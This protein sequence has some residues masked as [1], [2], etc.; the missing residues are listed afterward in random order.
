M[1]TYTGTTPLDNIHYTEFIEYVVD[2]NVRPERPED[3]E[4]PQL[5]NDMWALAEQCWAGDRTRRPDGNSLCRAIDTMIVNT[6][7]N[8][9]LTPGINSNSLPLSGTSSGCSL[10]N[11]P[12]RPYTLREIRRLLAGWNKAHIGI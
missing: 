8:A 7:D 10:H 2:R 12:Q 11:I 3:D 6:K 1:Q 4:V 9:S 5:S